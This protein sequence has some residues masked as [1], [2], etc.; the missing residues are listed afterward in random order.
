MNAPHFLS[1]GFM[2]ST[3]H[4]LFPFSLF[5]GITVIGLIACRVEW[6]Q[7]GHGFE[8]RGS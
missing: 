7:R 3:Y 8:I 1:Y 4:L 5:L 2:S 6:R